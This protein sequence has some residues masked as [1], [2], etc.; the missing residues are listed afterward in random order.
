MGRSPIT[1]LRTIVLSVYSCISA[2]S[3]CEQYSSQAEMFPCSRLSTE[4]I[5]FLGS[6]MSDLKESNYEGDANGM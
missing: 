6:S 1:I 2:S 4:D 3:G 5:F